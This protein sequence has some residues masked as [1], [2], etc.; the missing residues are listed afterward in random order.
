MEALAFQPKLA[1]LDYGMGNL[2]S[3]EQAL[4]HVGARVFRA[5]S[6]EALDTADALVLPGVGALGDCMA[7][8]AH[9]KLGDAIGGW[10]AEDRPFLGI[11]LGLQALFEHS[12]EGNTQGLG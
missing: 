6:P 7:A 3:V 5:H 11:C 8:L 10:I 4:E 2:R 9:H 12:E 1:V